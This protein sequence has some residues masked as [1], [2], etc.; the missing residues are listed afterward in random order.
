MLPVALLMARRVLWR[1]SGPTLAALLGVAACTMPAP[2]PSRPP[3]SQRPASPGVPAA[4]PSRPVGPITEAEWR[5]VLAQHILDANRERVF[6]GRPP[7]PLKA[8]VVLEL[9]IGADG[10]LQRAEVLRAPAHARH[11]GPEAVRTAQAAAPLPPPPSS[12]AGRGSIRIA[13][14]W[15]F[16][17]DERFQLRTLAETQLIE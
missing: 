7:H 14:T 12:L 13:E 16:R 17:A 6:E 9:T 1:W 5:R 15:L 4:T 2:E 3:P 10:R 8:I 11:L